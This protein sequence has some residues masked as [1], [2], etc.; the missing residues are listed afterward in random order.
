MALF[1]LVTQALRSHAKMCPHDHYRCQVVLRADEEE[2]ASVRVYAAAT[3]SQPAGPGCGWR[4][5]E[6]RRWR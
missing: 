5:Y 4:A 1:W 2:Q 6:S 3:E